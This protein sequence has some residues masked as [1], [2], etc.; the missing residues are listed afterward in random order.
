MDFHEIWY[1]AVRLKCVNI[2][3]FIRHRQLNFYS[4]SGLWVLC[5]HRSS[6]EPSFVPFRRNMRRCRDPAQVGRQCTATRSDRPLP[7]RTVMAIGSHFNGIW[8]TEFILSFTIIPQKECIMG[9]C[10]CP[11]V[12]IFNIRAQLSRWWL[13][14]YEY[15]P[16][17][18]Y[19]RGK[20]SLWTGGCPVKIQS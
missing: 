14:Q 10:V 17:S 4:K 9:C 16:T 3:K 2:F 13:W 7:Y 5:R 15:I 12:C 18:Q 11:S 19:R 1:G 8:Y 20:L 6:T